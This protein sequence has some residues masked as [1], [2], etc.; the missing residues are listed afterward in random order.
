MKCVSSA[1]SAPSVTMERRM[2]MESKNK[3]NKP[4]PVTVI[5][6][7]VQGKVDNDVS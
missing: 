3:E 4:E 5:E 1:A 6:I 7:K 2:D